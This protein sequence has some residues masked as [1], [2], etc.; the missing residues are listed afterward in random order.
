MKV[1]ALLCLITLATANVEYIYADYSDDKEFTPAPKFLT[2]SNPLIALTGFGTAFMG[3]I[4]NWGKIT[5][6]LKTTSSNVVKEVL[7]NRG[8]QRFQGAGKIDVAKGISQTNLPRYLELTARRWKIQPADGLTAG[9]IMEEKLLSDENYFVEFDITTSGPDGELRFN[10]MHVSQ[11]NDKYNF[12]RTT[13]S[14]TFVM[15]PDIH[16]IEKKKSILGGIFESENTIREEIPKN[17][18]VEDLQA[19]RQF[20]LAFGYSCIGKEMGFNLP[21]PVSS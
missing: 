6:A 20:M 2:K 7:T 14:A 13:I 8:F 5:S 4:D 9:E 18:N 16:V 19:V 11:S 1:I 12:V 10:T 3:V 17:V 15:A 21:M